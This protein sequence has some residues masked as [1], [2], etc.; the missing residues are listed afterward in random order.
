MISWETIGW[1]ATV[2]SLLCHVPQVIKVYRTKSTISISI[3]MYIFMLGSLSLWGYY[4]WLQGYK[5]MIAFSFCRAVFVLYVLI[6][7][8][9]YMF[10]GREV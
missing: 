1:G 6:M 9:Y 3:G 2:A 8:S 7:K 5:P 10:K 4:G